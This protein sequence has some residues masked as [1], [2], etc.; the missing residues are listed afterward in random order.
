MSD[1][2][3]E[4]TTTELRFSREIYRGEALDE[5]VKAFAGFARFELSERDECWVVD[6]TP[7][8]PELARRLIG[9]FSNYALGLTI[10]RGDGD[11]TSDQGV[12]G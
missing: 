1:P 4:S 8:S 9:E 2:A 11:T 7:K 3:T 10:Q 12:D 5:A 6:I